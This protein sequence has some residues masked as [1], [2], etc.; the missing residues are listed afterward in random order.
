[1]AAIDV[2]TYVLEQKG[3][4]SAMKLQK[5]VYYSQAWSLVWDERPLF[6]ESIE[7]WA[8]G[9]VCPAL[10]ARHRGN[11]LVTAGTFGGNSAILDATAKET[12]DRVL[13]FY[14]DK[15]AQWLSE[16]THIERP[17][18]EARDGVPVGARCS[19]VIEHAA[20]AEYYAAL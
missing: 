13:E 16:L 20:M 18:L 17:W 3:E 2:A 14:G 19:N 15:P 12:I 6:D 10:Y 1:M 11:F 8:N 5:L 4:M 7:A 9:P